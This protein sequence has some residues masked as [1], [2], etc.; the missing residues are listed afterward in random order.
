MFHKGECEMITKEIVPRLVL[1]SWRELLAIVDM[2]PEVLVPLEKLSGTI[3]DYG[4]RGEILYYPINDYGTL[5]EDVLDRLVNE[6]VSRIK[7]GKKTAVF[8]SGGC[9]RTGYVAGCILHCLGVQDPVRYLRQN[10]HACAVETDDQ[11]YAV[12]MYCKRHPQE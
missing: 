1:G 11:E 4:F 6:V 12:E 9:G 7:A 2:E 3:W 5:P 10:Y 8:C